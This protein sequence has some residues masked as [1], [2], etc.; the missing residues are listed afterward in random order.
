MN[1]NYQTWN[2]IE[3]DPKLLRHLSRRTNWH[4]LLYLTYFLG[5]LAG[6]G[7]L[8]IASVGTWWCVLTFFLYSSVWIFATSVV[9][10]ASHRTAFKNRSLNEAVLFIFGFMVQQTPCLLRYTH[11]RHHSQTAIVGDDPEILLA[12]PMTWKDFVFKQLIGVKSIWYFLKATTLL[13]I[14]RPSKDAVAYIPTRKMSHA[15]LEAQAYTLAYLAIVGWSIATQSWLPVLML[16]LPRMF[17]SLTHGVIIATQH[18]GLAQNIRDHRNTTRTMYLN[19]LHR[20]LYWNMNYHIEHHMYVQIPFH[21]MPALHQAVKKQCPV[22]TRGILGALREI[23]DTIS[24]Q[25]QD[26]SYSLQR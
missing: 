26:P 18:I 15:I 3:I 22:P 10:E 5:L 8:A 16:L 24:R 19:P 6:T 11:A 2:R 12:N 4:G 7:A 17:G 9:H 23:V 25:K 14:H 21:A 20:V 1:E 13:A